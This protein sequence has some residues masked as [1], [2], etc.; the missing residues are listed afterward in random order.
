MGDVHLQRP[1]DAKA[2]VHSQAVCDRAETEARTD[3][4][5]DLPRDHKCECGAGRH[6][7]VPLLQARLQTSQR[8]M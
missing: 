8:N 2:L 1:T 3:E 6:A 7:H 4:H 5:E